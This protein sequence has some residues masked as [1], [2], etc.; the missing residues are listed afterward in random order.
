MQTF[1]SD[2]MVPKKLKLKTMKWDL[3]KLEKFFFIQ[4]FFGDILSLRQ[5]FFYQ[6][7]ILDFF[8]L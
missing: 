8:T 4:N 3:A 5:V 7:K 1:L 6:Q 2:K